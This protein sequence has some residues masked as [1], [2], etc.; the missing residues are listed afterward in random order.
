[1]KINNNQ[2]E[3]I[4]MYNGINKYNY[5]LNLNNPKIKELYLRYKKYINVP[6]NIPLSDVQRW[7]FEKYID[8]VMPPR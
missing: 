1:M 4:S 8:D 2:S 6:A 3:A 7:E 5:R